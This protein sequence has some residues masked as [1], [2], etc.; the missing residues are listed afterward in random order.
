MQ[1]LDAIKSSL[2]PESKLLTILEKDV[3]WLKM[4]KRQ[5]EAHLT[6]TE[7]WS[8][9]LGKWRATVQSVEVNICY[10]TLFDYTLH[11]NYNIIKI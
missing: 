5:M 6:R 9:Y 2:K 8:E 11:F 7:I 4:E 10:Y 3:D 1:A